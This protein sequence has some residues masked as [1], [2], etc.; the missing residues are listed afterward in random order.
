MYSHYSKTILKQA[1]VKDISISGIKFQLKEDKQQDIEIGDRM[2][3]E[4][5]LNDRP[6]AVIN[7]NIVIKNINGTTVNAQ[8]VE[9]VSFEKDLSLKIF[10]CC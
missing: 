7:R 9:S 10:L 8:F 6:G 5:R 2:A 4:F 1:L 3:V